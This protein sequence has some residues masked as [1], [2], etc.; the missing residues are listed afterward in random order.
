MLMNKLPGNNSDRQIQIARLIP[1]LSIG[2]LLV[3]SYFIL[4]H[5]GTGF[6]QSAQAQVDVGRVGE[7]IVETVTEAAGERQGELAEAEQE[8]ADPGITED[9]EEPMEVPEEIAPED[10]PPGESA[11][12]EEEER[13]P[14]YIGPESPY[15]TSSE[16]LSGSSLESLPSDELRTLLLMLPQ[17]QGNEGALDTLMP[18][19][20]RFQLMIQ[21]PL[22][23]ERFEGEPPWMSDSA[24]YS[25]FDPVGLQPP[26]P[27]S[28]RP[29]PPFRP[30]P[31]VEGPTQG[32]DITAQMVANNINLVGVM[33]E[34]GEYLAILD[35]GGDQ[36][37]VSVG[38]EIGRRGEYAYLVDEISFGQVRIVREGRPEDTGIIFFTEQAGAGGVQ[39]ISIAY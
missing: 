18:I 30:I 38:D 11:E 14:V 6:M 12:P 27:R 20:Q 9:E 29:V 28:Q 23:Y 13:E 33:G 26:P 5:S 7:Q 4:F 2:V 25:P 39:E 8:M 34:E 10:L 17:M 24:R 37:V 19:I 35:I 22:A 36:K 3:A 31:G 32:P 21:P 16:G 15:Y 1:Y